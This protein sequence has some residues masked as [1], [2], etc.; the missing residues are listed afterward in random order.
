MSE[1]HNTTNLDTLDER[2]HTAVAL[3]EKDL[4]EKDF[5]RSVQVYFCSNIIM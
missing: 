2:V 3:L 4:L 1:T 5:P